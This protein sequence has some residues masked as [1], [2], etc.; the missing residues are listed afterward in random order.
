MQ[1]RISDGAFASRLSPW[2]TDEPPF[3]WLEEEEEGEVEE[4]ERLKKKQKDLE[5]ELSD[6]RKRQQ[7]QNGERNSRD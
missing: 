5:K 1:P 2:H 4:I 6:R 3:L 7:E